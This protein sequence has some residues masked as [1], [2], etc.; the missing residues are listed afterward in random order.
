MTPSEEPKSRTVI[1]FRTSM[2]KYKKLKKLV[3]KPNKSLSDVVN[4]A[5]NTYLSILEDIEKS[6]SKNGGE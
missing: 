5:V 4:R 6:R 2:G 1:S 3:D